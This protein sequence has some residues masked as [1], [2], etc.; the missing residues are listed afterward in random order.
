MI[1]LKGGIEISI[2]IDEIMDLTLNYIRLGGSPHI[3]LNGY[4]TTAQFIKC[5]KELYSEK[6]IDIVF[7][8]KYHSKSRII[9]DRL[10]KLYEDGTIEGSKKEGVREWYFRIPSSDKSNVNLIENTL[11]N[12][13]P[14]YYLKGSGSV[15]IFGDLINLTSGG[16][17]CLPLGFGAY[18][19]VKFGEGNVK[20][21]VKKN[22]EITSDT[23]FLSVN[24]IIK[25]GETFLPN[26]YKEISEDHDLSRNLNKIQCNEFGN[27]FDEYL[28]RCKECDLQKDCEIIS[29]SLESYLMTLRKYDYC[30]CFEVTPKIGYG[31]SGTIAAFLATVAFL[32]RHRNV[33]LSIEK[34]NLNEQERCLWPDITGIMDNNRNSNSKSISNLL[35][36]L[37]GKGVIK[38]KKLFTKYLRLCQAI[39][40]MINTEHDAI[41][42]EKG[43]K[44]M[45]FI[46]YSSC[47]APLATLFGRPMK[48]HIDNESR[49]DYETSKVLPIIPLNPYL[50]LLQISS[51]HNSTAESI[52][53][54]ID[55][56]C[57]VI[58]SY[59]IGDN[60]K[61]DPKEIV[62]MLKP[63][64]NYIVE[65]ASALLPKIDTDI[66]MRRGLISIM[67]LQQ[68]IYSALGLNS[69][70]I[71]KISE[72]ISKNNGIG[73]SSIGT[74][75]SSIIL[76][77]FETADNRDLL[78]LI[79]QKSHLFKNQFKIIEPHGRAELC[80]SASPLR[81]C[82]N[83]RW[84]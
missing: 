2:D 29:R 74:G 14:D 12:F 34:D 61:I 69:D 73:L 37:K 82:K 54:C 38:K 46:T 51:E 56:M 80:F 39:E 28:E 22:G 10:R 17:I 70:T 65:K 62:E 15:Y 63:I 26:R 75:S 60:E 71:D 7:G 83:H 84:D 53:L 6:E 40:D 77:C 76:S 23:T 79:N 3:I 5:M 13:N 47:C 81:Y 57:K 48:V 44:L 49:L 41:D 25:K 33:I 36:D 59:Q 18:I 43:N 78:N 19:G 64:N 21:L 30:I 52:Q 8:K 24:R 68:S 20:Y 32:D 9:G 72:Y 11:K 67:R 50:G 27:G 16:G 58:P 1:N 4:F 55:T 66:H 31:M 35:E 42:V 45:G